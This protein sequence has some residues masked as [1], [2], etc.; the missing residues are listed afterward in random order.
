VNIFV[1]S[2]ITVFF[3]LA[4]ASFIRELL[5]RR[6]EEREQRRQSAANNYLDVIARSA[7]ETPTMTFET[8][9]ELAVGQVLT[10]N[11]G[12]FDRPPQA[13]KMVV[14]SATRNEIHKGGADNDIAVNGGDVTVTWEIGLRSVDDEFAVADPNESRPE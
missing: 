1:S 14:V 11:L 12:Y 5:R 13:T 8:D 10:V 6:E 3:A 7:R 2:F 9:R 4:A